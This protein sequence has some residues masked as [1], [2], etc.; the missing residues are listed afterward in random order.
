MYFIF[1]CFQFCEI[2]INSNTSD[3]GYINKTK[4]ETE[5]G[6]TS[7]LPS[8]TTEKGEG[9]EGYACTSHEVRG[10]SKQITKI[11]TCG[12]LRGYLKG[13]RP[14]NLMLTNL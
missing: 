1:F 8:R 5:D 12:F 11:K 6:L 13:L 14:W 4:T 10:R 9:R 3:E 7:S 2:S